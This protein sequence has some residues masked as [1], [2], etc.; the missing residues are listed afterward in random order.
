MTLRQILVPKPNLR[1]LGLLVLLFLGGA[2]VLRDQI[3]THIRTFLFISQEF[4]QIPIKPLHAVTKTPSSERI[5]FGDRQ[6]VIA[7]IAAPSDRRR[8][9]A[10]ILALGL[11]VKE[12]DKP[13]ILAVVEN[14]AR[15][16]YVTMWPRSQAVDEAMARPDS[17]DRC[18]DPRVLVE[19]FKYMQTRPGVKRERISFIGVSGGSSL[20]LV[21]AEDPAVAEQ[22]RALVCFGGYYNLLDYL[23][24]LATSQVLVEGEPIMWEPNENIVARIRRTL[25]AEGV[26]LDIFRKGTIPD[27]MR[28]Q[29]RRLSPDSGIEA[30]KARAFILHDKMDTSVPAIESERLR[31][32][33]AGR[34]PVTY[35]LS[36]LVQHF[37]P[38]EGRDLRSLKELLALY[39]FVYHVFAYL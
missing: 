21:A 26:S 2:C 6:R 13:M 28:E 11:G 36:T 37:R 4:P 39:R 35:L 1:R 8:H 9:P 30:I 31:Q 19:S 3:R 10:L 23:T 15:L 22:A 7:D 14:F 24:A 18:E 20:A 5:E 27:A 38:K 34:V 32:A 25:A 33:L 16:G 29:L 17:I 12:H